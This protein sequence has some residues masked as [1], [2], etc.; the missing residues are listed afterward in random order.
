MNTKKERIRNKKK[1]GE[2]LRITTLECRLTDC[3]GMDMF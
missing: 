2:N 3:D 1:M